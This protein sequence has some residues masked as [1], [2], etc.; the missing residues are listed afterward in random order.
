MARS[1]TMARGAAMLLAWGTLVAGGCASMPAREKGEAKTFTFEIGTDANGCPISATVPEGQRNCGCFSK[2][3]DCVRAYPGDR[4][5]VVP[6]GG[7]KG[8]KARPFQLF[9]DPFHAGAVR[10]PPGEPLTID[11]NAPP[12]TYRF[13]IVAEGCPVL[14]PEIIVVKN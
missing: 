14:D 6:A 12:K 13:N 5:L 9:F 3:P 1:E 2:R 4:I 8:M 11:R 10:S 7:P